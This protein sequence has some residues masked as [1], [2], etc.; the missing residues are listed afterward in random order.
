MSDGGAR[1]EAARAY[2]AAY[3]AHYSKRDLVIA[4]QLYTKLIASHAPARSRY[5]TLS[6]LVLAE[7]DVHEAE[8]GQAGRGHIRK[9]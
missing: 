1:T 7:F 5:T 3:A 9:H 6:P 4:F 2:A 8:R